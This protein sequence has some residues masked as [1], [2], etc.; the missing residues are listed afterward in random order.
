RKAGTAAAAEVGRLHHLH[1]LFGSVAR[2]RLA[3]RL[4]AA[5]LEID[6]DRAEAGNLPA[7]SQ[8]ALG[9]EGD[10][11]AAATGSVERGTCFSRWIFR[12]SA[13][14]P[15]RTPSGRGGQP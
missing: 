14:R 15:S 8:E 11:E 5:V 13:I 12:C 2:Q 7:T 9:H 10:Q 1:Q 6:V 4:V 3:D